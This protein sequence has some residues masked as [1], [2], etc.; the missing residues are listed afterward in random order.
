MEPPETLAAGDATKVGARIASRRKSLGMTQSDLA[1]LS[2]LSRSFVAKLETGRAFSPPAVQQLAPL[3]RTNDM[4]LLFGQSP[5][6]SDTNKNQS[7]DIISPESDTN[8]ADNRASPGQTRQGGEQIVIHRYQV[9]AGQLV[10]GMQFT[11]PRAAFP[12]HTGGANL[13]LVS[14]ATA[15]T[16]VIDPSQA[17]PIQDGRHYLIGWRR[18]ILMPRIYLGPAGTISCTAISTL[19]LFQTA[20][21][22]ARS[23][24]MAA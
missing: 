16:A 1:Q 18:S 23:P 17:D 11:A 24:S 6:S 14:V 2:K 9:E 10:P 7:P 22:A 4:F 13:M 8:E 20:T 3:L 15:S 12:N 21:S 19:T 5:Q